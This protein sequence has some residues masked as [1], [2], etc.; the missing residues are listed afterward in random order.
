M[1]AAYCKLQSLPDEARAAN[2]I[3]SKARLDCTAF[4][5]RVQGGY[6]GLEAFRNSKGQLAFYKTPARDIVEAHSKRIAEWVLSDGKLNLSSLYV[7]DFEFSQ[8]AY[9]YPNA[10]PFI[11]KER[12]PNPL[13]PFRNDGYL[14]IVNAD[15]SQ[16]ELLIFQEARNLIHSHYQRLI[17]GAFDEDLQRCRDEAKPYFNYLGL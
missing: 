6:K 10:N 5:D 8:Y 1:I 17:D 16:I 15:Y 2:K 13:F 11:G 14:F 4:I 7:E 3:R 12:K 9:G